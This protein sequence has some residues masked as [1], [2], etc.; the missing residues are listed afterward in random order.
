MTDARLVGTNPETSELVPVAVNAQGQLKT[1][2]A[3]IEEIPNDLLVSGD[4]TVTGTIN[5]GGISLPPDPYEG[6]LL[7]WENNQLAWIGTP[8][9]PIPEGVF[10]P[11]KSWDPESSYLEVE[12]SIPS[13]LGTGVF[14][15][16]CNA[17]GEL[18]MP[19][20]NT[21][22]DWSDTAQGISK[23]SGELPDF[24][25][26]GLTSASP[27]FGLTT[28]DNQYF[29]YDRNIP[30]DGNSSIQVYSNNAGSPAYKINKK[31][32]THIQQNGYNELQI[33]EGET[34]LAHVSVSLS[35]H[36]E[37]YGIKVNGKTL[38]NSSNT[39]SLRIQSILPNG[40]VGTPNNAGVSFAVGQ[41]LKVPSQRVAP[42]L[43]YGNDPTSYIDYLRSRRD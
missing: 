29:F 5:G 39:L 8:P 22:E 3:K 30:L 43:L 1:E 14:V 12:G 7:G 10:G 28:G 36:S 13:G 19:D 27:W 21:S 35:G 31:A 23:W 18:F 37:Q 24:F 20:C 38:V 17:A 11:I 32:V 40:F 16:Q 2:I 33:P 26:G 34:R 4:L 15:Y 6:A 41:Y 42:W 9:V 25:N